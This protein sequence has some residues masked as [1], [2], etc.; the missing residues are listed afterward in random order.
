MVPAYSIKVSRVSWY[1]GGHWSY[2]CLR[3]R[4]F[5]PLWPVFP[6]PFRW[7]VSIVCDSEPQSARTLVWALSVSLAATPKIT[8]VFSSSGYLDVSVHR[9]P[10]TTLWIHV[11]VP[12]VCPG[13]FPHSD[14]CGSWLI[15]SSPQLFAAYHV[16]HR[17]LVPRHP[18]CALSSL[19]ISTIYAVNRAPHKRSLWRLIVYHFVVWAYSVMLWSV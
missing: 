13:G 3:L 19:T 4:G 18:P 9:V 15:C 1:S 11:V 16:F 7:L 17:L 2:V 12:G 5:H 8:I 6:E 14:I 10:S